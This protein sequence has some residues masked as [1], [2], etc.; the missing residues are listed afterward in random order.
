VLLQISAGVKVLDRVGVGFTVIVNDWAVPT[1]PSNEGVTVIVAVTGAVPPLVAVKGEI[2]PV[3]DPARLID[4][5]LLVH[6][7]VEEPPDLI[8][9]KFIASVSAPL[10]LVWSAGSLTWPLGLTVIVNVWG[11]PAH[12]SNEGETVIVAIA[13]VLPVFVVAKDGIFPV[14]LAP[15]PMEVLLLDHEYVVDPPLLSVVKFT[16]AVVAPTHRTWSAGSFTCPDGLT[17]IVNVCCAPTH[18][19]NVGVTVIVAVKGEVPLLVAV[20]AA[21]LPVPDPARPIEVLLFVHAK[22]EDP[23]VLEVEKFTA[24]V[25]APLHLVWSAGSFTCP[26][27]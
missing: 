3:P 15:R 25:A 13:G 18:P 23:P 11:V 20:N 2:L 14:P 4:V 22:E 5:L 26:D 10:H 6:E 17:V 12:P 21:I 9:A 27:G 8:V 7:N 19:S 24:A 16:A 1:H